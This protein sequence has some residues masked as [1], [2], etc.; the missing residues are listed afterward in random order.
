MARNPKMVVWR[1][2]NCYK[3]YAQQFFVSA[4]LLVRVVGNR[5]SS[6]AVGNAVLDSRAIA[7][8]L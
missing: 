6:R 5:T 1:G 7:S 4:P 8:S 3:S 2:R